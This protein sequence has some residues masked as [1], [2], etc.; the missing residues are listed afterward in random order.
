[1]ATTTLHES[2]DRAALKGFAS[3]AGE[4]TTAQR[5]G[6][7]LDD[8][9]NLIAAQI[10]ALLDVP[11]VSL[12]LRED[13]TGTF[14]GQVGF[15]ADDRLIKRLTGGLEADRFTREVAQTK[16]PVVIADAMT[17]PRTI[18]STMREWGVRSVI[19]VPMVVND[20]VIGLLFAD[21]KEERR[22]FDIG[23]EEVAS[24]FATLAAIAVQQARLT[25]DLQGAKGSLAR[26][27]RTLKTA[28]VVDE[29][30]TRLVI[31]GCD[32]DEI[33]TTV[34]NLVAAP[35]VIFDADRRQVAASSTEAAAALTPELFGAC[36]DSDSE[37]A[38][39]IDDPGRRTE[40]V[41]PFTR[42]GLRERLLLAP[43]NAGG[44]RL[45]TLV[46]VEARRR[47]AD[48]DVLALRRAANVV[49]VEMV[50]RRRVSAA[51][52]DARSSLAAHLIHGTADPL[53]RDRQ[54]AFLGVDLSLPRIVCL[55]GL[56]GTTAS[57][58]GRKVASHLE[59]HSPGLECFATSVTEGVALCLRL[60][61]APTS[62]A[63]HARAKELVREAC[64]E[65]VDLG[66]IAASISALCTGPDD[67]P[68]AYSAAQEV[69]R[70]VV[71]FCPPRTRA[72]VLSAAD[73]GA[74]RQ[75]LASIDREA[76]AGY[77][78]ETF[79]PLDNGR[80]SGEQLMLTLQ[81]FFE[82][83]ASIKS[84][85]RA[86]DVHDNTI[87]Y[88]LARIEDLTGYSFENADDIL[89]IH[90]ALKILEL[91]RLAEDDPA[92]PGGDPLSAAP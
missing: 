26:Q 8:V 63:A 12:Y 21:A 64:A 53:S 76:A 43:V 87:R 5:E 48:V 29:K 84:A 34:A 89:R 28:A 24:A 13:A 7:D 25:S 45:G 70:C 90:L 78:A 58:D 2:P 36:I 10:G 41:G 46:E 61:D 74:A 57:F 59:A 56:P 33:V 18:S 52:W 32:L 17:D 85:A 6:R 69:L 60:P 20:E 9:L 82:G 51:E 72:S 92:D 19:G 1:M 50:A 83:C 55:F 71:R 81:V 67:Y 73:V 77:A 88:R 31:D 3:I 35:C 49:A 39:S 11:R 38:R 65:L 62:A 40:L 47:I 80:R 16:R 86:L 23:D 14:R 42:Q 79:G 30:L 22:A 66:P 4:L 54:A 68:A 27:N 75:F 37:L 15:G 91:Q 44:E